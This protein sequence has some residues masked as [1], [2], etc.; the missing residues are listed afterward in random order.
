MFTYYINDGFQYL[1]AYERDE[2]M[3][4]LTNCFSALGC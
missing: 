1:P 4:L 2:Q 3:E